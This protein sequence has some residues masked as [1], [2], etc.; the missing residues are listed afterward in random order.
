MQEVVELRT[1]SRELPMDGIRVQG[2]FRNARNPGVLDPSISLVQ[3]IGKKGK[4]ITT[5]VHFACH[6]ESLSKGSREMSADFPGYMC[7]QIIQDGGGQAIF[8]NGAVGGMVSG[9][10]FARTHESAKDMGL[11]LAEIVKDMIPTAASAGKH[12][13]SVDQRLLQI[14]TTNPDFIERF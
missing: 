14:P 11:E 5:M 7:D 6:V 3:A 10:N 2:L 13:F 9:D 1:A 12:A 8:L 4:V